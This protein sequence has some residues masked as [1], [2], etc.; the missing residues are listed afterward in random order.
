MDKVQELAKSVAEG[1]FSLV[2]DGTK[3]LNIIDAVNSTFSDILPLDER[4]DVCYTVLDCLD[5][6]Y[7]WDAPRMSEEVE[8]GFYKIMIQWR[9]K[10]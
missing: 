8:R 2:E 4:R 5:T 7:G 3:I 1:G 6:E 9:I 10:V